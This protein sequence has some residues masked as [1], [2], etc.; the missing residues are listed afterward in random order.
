MLRAAN[1]AFSYGERRVLDGVSLALDRG[2]VLGVLGPNGAGKST[3][4]RV[5]LGL[6]AP[7]QGSVIIDDRPLAGLSIRERARHLAAVLQNEQSTFAFTVRELALF[8][9]AGKSESDVAAV[10]AALR[11]ADA[12]AF[13]DRPLMA[14]SGG[15]RQRA[16]LA[17]A[18]AQ[19][20][21]FLV[22]DEPT[23]YMDLSHQQGFAA[24]VR[25][26]ERC[27]VLWILHDPDLALRY[28]SQVLVLAGGRIAASGKPKDVLTPELLATVFSV[29]AERTEDRAGAPHLLVTAALD[30]R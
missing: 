21:P 3:L 19:D 16:L 14:L 9:R 2:E 26:L 6:L 28:C 27:G 18:L 25:S 1:I 5:V 23:A 10:E 8:A 30:P 13:A 11:R 22:L 17:R 15:E 7:A 12:H 24:L 20:T 4:A 29:H